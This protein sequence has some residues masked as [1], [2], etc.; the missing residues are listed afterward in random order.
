MPGSWT[1]SERGQLDGTIAD[2]V[3]GGGPDKGAAALSSITYLFCGFIC[4]VIFWHFIG[5]WST[6]HD[7]VLRGPDRLAAAEHRV[8]QW[9]PSCTA[10][11]LDRDNGVTRS[12]A[13]AASG[14]QMAESAGYRRDRL[15]VGQVATG[16][17]L[18]V[19]MSW[20]VVVNELLEARPSDPKPL[21]GMPHEGIAPP[22]R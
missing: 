12:E 11:V 8:A 18:A 5:F 9:G 13:C 4:G 15:P 10:L 3:G 1:P 20:T 7:I 21:V 6:F 19:D 14:S 22:S 2:P 17:P 16:R